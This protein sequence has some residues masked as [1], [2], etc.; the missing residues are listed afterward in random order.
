M[1]SP[2]DSASE[3]PSESVSIDER[4]TRSSQ[5]RPGS[6]PSDSALAGRQTNSLTFAGKVA[7]A[8]FSYSPTTD[9]QARNADL[10]ELALP[11]PLGD[12]SHHPSEAAHREGARGPG[13]D[14]SAH[15]G[16]LP[17]L[18]GGRS[19]VLRRQS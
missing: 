4:A 17:C 8:L 10:M 14:L 2:A 13:L 12:P 1:V 5:D 7:S 16:M 19:I 11:A 18:R 9:F 3:W 6:D 15:N